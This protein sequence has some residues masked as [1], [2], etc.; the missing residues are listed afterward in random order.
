[1]SFDAIIIYED[2]AVQVQE[3]GPHNVLCALL[4]DEL[5]KSLYD[6]RKRLLGIP[7]KGSGKLLRACS[8]RNVE[9]LARQGQLVI[10]LVDDD[11]VHELL[12]LDKNICRS[13]VLETFRAR[14]DNPPNLIIVLLEK[15]TED[16]LRIVSAIMKY[17]PVA[18]EKA[19]ERKDLVA[20]DAV[21]NRFAFRAL[22]EQRKNL[23]EMMPSF[24]RLVGVVKKALDRPDL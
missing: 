8:A 16:L 24:Q 6:V 7:A 14:V 18:L 9:K 4:A 13:R 20:R 10:T 23:L 15:N 17:S 3:F 19:I 1:M 12:G 5:N 22:A 11:R 21:L 2:K